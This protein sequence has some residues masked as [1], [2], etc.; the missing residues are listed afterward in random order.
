MTIEEVKEQPR[1][2]THSQESAVVPGKADVEQVK[3]VAVT[4]TETAAETKGES[5]PASPPS[6]T[7]EAGKVSRDAHGEWGDVCG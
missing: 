7:G 4:P 5:A 1:P 6:K 3:P 2:E